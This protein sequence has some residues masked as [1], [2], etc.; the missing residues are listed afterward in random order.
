MEGCQKW[1]I[2]VVQQKDKFIL[3]FAGRGAKIL[4]I[5]LLPFSVH[6]GTENHEEIKKQYTS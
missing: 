5:L 3:F 4:K 6:G 2:Y 1:Y